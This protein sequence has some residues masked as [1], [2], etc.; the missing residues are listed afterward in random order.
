MVMIISIRFRSSILHLHHKDSAWVAIQIMVR[1]R[2]RMKVAIIPFL[3]I[4]QATIIMI[5]LVILPMMVASNKT[6]CRGE[7]PMVDS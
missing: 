4:Y 2:P 5:M 6:L 7:G 1:C 3:M